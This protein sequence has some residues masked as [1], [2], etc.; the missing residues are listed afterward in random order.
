MGDS[1]VIERLIENPSA[2]TWAL[3]PPLTLGKVKETMT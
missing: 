3:T 1:M 2:L